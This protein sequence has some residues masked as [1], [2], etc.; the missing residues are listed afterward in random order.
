MVLLSFKLEKR[1]G[2]KERQMCGHEEDDHYH[3]HQ[4]PITHR[5]NRTTLLTFNIALTHTRE[6]NAS[7]FTEYLAV[8]VWVIATLL[9]VHNAQK[10][11]HKKYTMQREFNKMRAFFFYLCITYVFWSSMHIMHITSVSLFVSFKMDRIKNVI[12]QLTYFF[13]S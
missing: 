4:H 9:Y 13:T 11:I 10:Y 1:Q 8:C 3:H 7:L 5:K 12:C 6:V 2:K